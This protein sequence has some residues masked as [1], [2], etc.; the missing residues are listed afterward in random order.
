M[1]WDLVS[2]M[3]LNVG[4]LIITLLVVIVLMGIAIFGYLRWAR[5]KEYKC[6]ILERDGF[7]QLR[8]TVD[9]AGVFV[10]GK[11]K[12]KR[13]F[14]KKNNVG[15]RA[16]DVPYLSD[17]KGKKTVYLLKTG[18]K[19]FHFIQVGVNYPA[20][21]LTVGEEDVNWAI[22]AY[23]RQK[24]IFNSESILM[25]LLPYMALV[26]VSIII[27]IIFV[28]FFKSFEDLGKFAEGM[29]EAMS[30]YA[31]SKSGTTVIGG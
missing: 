28:Y 7:G 19:N 6:V 29:K 11:T 17:N 22:N 21:T 30:Y 16:D 2:R 13:L 31:Q 15:L 14:L 1:E 9:K 4:V 25:Q 18:L 23:D 3:I 10:D 24:K 26:F 27:I 8:Q 20:V 12:N 5:Y